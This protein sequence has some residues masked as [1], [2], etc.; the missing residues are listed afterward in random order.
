MPTGLE[1]LE[2]LRE[3]GIS[4]QEVQAYKSEVSSDLH[5]AGVTD[6]EIRMHWGEKFP[7]MSGV[8]NQFK[9]NFKKA[10][11][12]KKEGE[13]SR[14]TP[15]K[16]QEGQPV[17]IQDEPVEEAKTFLDAVEAGF[18]MS[19][20][21]LLTEKPDVVLPENAEMFMRIA[22]GVGTLAGDF[23]AMVAG[24]LAGGSVGGFVGSAIPVGGTA[25]GAV[26]GGG[27]GAFALPSGMRQWLMDG[28]EKGTINSFDD[29]W[30]RASAA[31]IEGG[32][33][34]VIGAA[35]AGAGAAVGS[36]AKTAAPVVK[37]T[38]ALTTEVTTMTAIGG[39]MR[40]EVPEPVEFVEAAILIG[41]MKGAGKLTSKTAAKM[42]TKLRNM[43]ARD[44]A[45]PTDVYELAMKDPKFHKE[46]L[47]ENQP[48]PSMDRTIS[49]EA[50]LNT[51][52]REFLVSKDLP[53][54][55][56]KT[57]NTPEMQKVLESIGIKST[58]TPKDPDAPSGFREFYRKFVDKLDPIN[59]ATKAAESKTGGLKAEDNPYVAARMIP[60]A[61]AK[62]LVFFEKET[63][64]QKTFKKNGKS[65]NEI[66]QKSK[67]LESLEGF[68][69]SKR[70]LEKT[71]QEKVTGI[72]I[73]AAKKVVKNHAKEFSETAKAVTEFSN[74]TLEY[75]KDSG[76]LSDKQFKSF[77]E[78][79]KDYVPFKRLLEPEAGIF[80]SKGGKAGSLKAFKGSEKKVQ[81][82]I[83]SIVE[84]TVDL[85]Q[86]A[87]VNNAKIKFVE[88]IE[89]SGMTDLVTRVKNP[90]KPIR[91]SAKELSKK[92]NVSEELLNDITVFTAASRNLGKN[93]FE[94]IRDGKRQVYETKP[95]LADAL[96]KLGGDVSSSNVLVNLSR[97]V[98]Q[99]KKLTIT[100][101][102]DFIARNFFR[103]I[104]TASVFSVKKGVSPFQVAGAMKDMVG[105]SDTYWNWYKSG[106]ANG[107]F[108]ELNNKYITKNIT[109]LQKQTNFMDSAL[110]VAGKPIEMMRIGA[111]LVEQ[112]VRL[113]E[114][115][116]V[117]K[118]R[119]DKSS[120]IEG[121]FA[122]REIT[123]D[124]QRIGAKMSAFNAITA[125]QNVSIQGL[126]KTIRAFEAD[127]VRTGTKAM[128][129]I[130][131]PSVLLWWANKDDKRVKDLPG[132]QKAAFWIIPTDSWENVAPSDAEGLSPH[133][134]R[135]QGDKTQVNKGVIYRVP[136]PMELGLVFGT[137]PEMVLEKFFGDNPD[138]FAEF[139]D[140]MLN[141]L[142]PS[143]IPDI[144]VPFLE[145]YANKNFFTGRDIVPSHMEPL[146]N[147]YEYKDYTSETS[148]A[149]GKLIGRFD[150]DN[151]LASPLVISNYIRSWSGALGS[152]AVQVADEALRKSGVA[153]DIVKPTSTLADIP[154]IK[155]F[156]IRYP[157]AGSAQIE[158]FYKNFDKTET[159]MKT[160]KTLGKRGDFENLQK[161]FHDEENQKYMV[162]LKGVSKAL[163]SLRAS[164]SNV[165][166]N[167][168][169][170]KDDKR[171]LLDILYLRMSQTAG[172][173]NE[174]LKIRQET[175]EELKEK[176]GK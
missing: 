85:I 97:G 53:K 132:W 69:V 163:S 140:S 113:A 22:A 138:A 169:I 117:T 155:S 5:E 77:L 164:A 81:S 101:T 51:P 95:D 158:R 46:M 106:G 70:A 62:A 74:R 71:A 104:I 47:A 99:F 39:A 38:A 130:T 170:S 65:L 59:S 171:Q 107:A 66:L 129:Y 168:D 11:A 154:F 166:K 128:A 9:E 3:N 36:I 63:F 64:N 45:K 165:Y 26:V 35:T 43:Y 73:E 142:T 75:A 131:T 86:M 143:I 13:A 167:P 34:A 42:S 133:L 114:F 156:V 92:L 6:K 56:L 135:Q 27:A 84:N 125:F 82:P 91:V 96:Q 157:S 7:D 24:S 127:P 89:R 145:Q 149:L 78:L 21:G 124:F 8:E 2:S 150:A 31:F 98:T 50:L 175:L 37:S 20:T 146:I 161:E 23:P 15:P 121:G 108:L 61:K 172:M 94:V 14:E 76:L 152:Y 67:D 58:K 4:E 109:S 141:M 126:D 103:D 110:N 118:G 28:Y 136:K 151:A 102:P 147:E 153:E 112:G 137:L 144:A 12:T 83:T 44:G 80:Q 40:G 159:V 88:M 29:F 105:K 10:E 116:N 174:M 33:G 160:V 19:V 57:R 139:N 1:N 119:S 55:I 173:G 72:N 17:P 134:V 115:K 32:K 60:D 120:L 123:L 111:N 52:P 41:G 87:E 176:K 54:P 93:Q 122:A 68:M 48:I 79:N 30:E 100:F 162:N 49:K 90:A 148:K 16:T 25:V 18:D